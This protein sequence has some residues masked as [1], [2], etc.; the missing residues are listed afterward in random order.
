MGLLLLYY[1]GGLTRNV[2]PPRAWGMMIVEVLRLT[3]LEW[4]K[5]RRRWVPWILLGIVILI[6]QLTLWGA[7]FTYRTADIAEVL[8][9][10]SFDTAA[11]EVWECREIEHPRDVC[12]DQERGERLYRKFER[13]RFILP[14]SLANTLGFAQLFGPIL[15]AILASSAV[16]VEYGWGTLR[17][18]LTRGTR[19]WQFLAAK[20]VAIMLMVVAGLLVLS[21]TSVA[22]SLIVAWLTLSDGFGFTDSGEWSAVWVV[23]GKTVYSLVPYMVL[24]LFFTVLT[25]SAGVGTALVLGYYFIEFFVAGAFSDS[26]SDFLL[27]PNI[28]AWMQGAG[29]QSAGLTRISLSDLPDT[30]HAFLVILAHIVVLGAAAFWLFQRRDIAGARSE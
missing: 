18:T 12:E 26:I 11:G 3:R 20:V 13:P 4:F 2:L 7:F 8:K 1:S 29:A 19:R 23:F 5:L 10:T 24:A 28:A 21:L 6:A 16:G 15:V 22:S 30:S 27:G 25:S 14:I 9:F 17:T